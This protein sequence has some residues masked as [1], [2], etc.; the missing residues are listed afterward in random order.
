M[1]SRRAP[2]DR[3][4]PRRP[5]LDRARRYARRIRCVEENCLFNHGRQCQLAWMEAPGYRVMNRNRCPNYIIA[6]Q[7]EILVSL[8]TVF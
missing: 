7:N 2:D 3:T 4:M 6:D 1:P 8:S 5:P